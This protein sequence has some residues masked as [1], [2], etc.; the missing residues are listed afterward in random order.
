M[1][2]G[3][4]VAAILLALMLWGAGQ[5]GHSELKTAGAEQQAPLD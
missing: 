3:S 1:A 4:G 2:V 5:V